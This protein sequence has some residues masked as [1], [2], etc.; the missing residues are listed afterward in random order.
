[1]FSI[2]ISKQQASK[3]SRGYEDEEGVQNKGKG[4]QTDAE[5]EEVDDEEHEDMEYKM[6][7]DLAVY[8]E[9]SFYFNIDQLCAE[10]KQCYQILSKILADNILLSQEAVYGSDL[11][12]RLDADRIHSVLDSYMDAF[13][14]GE[15]AF[16]KVYHD[17]ELK[18]TAIKD[19]MKRMGHEDLIWTVDPREIKPDQYFVVDEPVEET[20]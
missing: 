16:D 11:R 15:D 3:T 19:A 20:A 14:N 18:L 6:Q 1:M 7:R 8:D 17:N 13:I 10:G 5:M 9:Q 2:S 4:Y 12:R